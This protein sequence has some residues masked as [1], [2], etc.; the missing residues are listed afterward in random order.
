MKLY[1]FFAF[2]KITLWYITQANSILG[3][4]QERKSRFF[5]YLFTVCI[6]AKEKINQ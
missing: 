5:T 3:N 4:G 1:T 2:A 6:I